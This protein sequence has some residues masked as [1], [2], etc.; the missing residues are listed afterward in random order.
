MKHYKLIWP[1]IQSAT[2]IVGALVLLLAGVFWSL[3][4][5]ERPGGLGAPLETEINTPTKPL[6][7]PAVKPPGSS[8]LHLPVPVNL[9][10]GNPLRKIPALKRAMANCDAES[11]KNLDELFFLV[12]PV[13]PATFEVATA[14]LPP[15]GH[16]YGSFFLVPSPALFVGLENG[17]LELSTRRYEFSIID[18]QTKQTQ[19]WS[20]AS[21]PSK[22]TYV[23]AADVAKFQI[24]FSFG[25]KGPTWSSGFDRQKGN[26]Y[27]V[28]LRFP[29]QPYSPSYGS[30]NLGVSK[31]FPA[32]ASTIRCANRVCEPILQ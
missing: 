13:E 15:A 11:A 6:K 20:S 17:S 12:T 21:G 29:G 4:V 16:D 28:N 5:Q 7:V 22:F 27:W 18:M 19:T 24:G 31:S 10:S 32:P 2:F 30:A 1:V 26:C 3:K 14:L 23:N 9:P 25:D 8:Q